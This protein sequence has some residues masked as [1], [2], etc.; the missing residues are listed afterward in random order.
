MTGCSNTGTAPLKTGGD[1]DALIFKPFRF[2]ELRDLIFNLN[3]SHPFSSGTR[4]ADLSESL[5]A[6]GFPRSNFRG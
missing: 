3:P 6:P 5:A 4:S 1:I 2:Q